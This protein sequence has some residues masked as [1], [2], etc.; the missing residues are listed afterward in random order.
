VRGEIK[1]VPLPA[2]M[3]YVRWTEVR[4]ADHSGIV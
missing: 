1:V 2:T 4:Y 3:I